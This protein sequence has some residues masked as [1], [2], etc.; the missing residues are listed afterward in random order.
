MGKGDGTL[1]ILLQIGTVFGLF[2]LSQ[3]IEAMLP[4]S[5]PASVI[6]LLPVLALLLLKVL[7]PAHIREFSDFLLGNLSFFFVPA[8]VGIISYA[9]AIRDNAA[10]FIVIC[11]VSTVVTFAATAWAVQLTC[12]LLNKKR[13]EK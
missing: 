11:V 4:F 1:K 10:A 5:F 8:A 9:D 12:R 3:C 13:G 6:S 7:K 2:W